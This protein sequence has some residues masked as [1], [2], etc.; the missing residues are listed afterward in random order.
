M[1]LPLDELV[2][3][4]AHVHVEADGHGHFSLDDELLA[5]SAQY[6]KSGDNRAPGIEQIATYYRGLSRS[7]RPASTGSRRP[8]VMIS[9]STPIRPGPP[10]A[11]SVRPSRTG[12]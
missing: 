9:G 4:D 3:I 7:T 8:P 6:F 10:K 1:A 2:A 12:S 5:A 11:P